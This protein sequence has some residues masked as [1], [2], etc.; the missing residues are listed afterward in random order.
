MAKT[1]TKLK[2]KIYGGNRP[3]VKKPSTKGKKNTKKG[4]RSIMGSLAMLRRTTKKPNLKKKPN[5]K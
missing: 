3:T 2:S 5:R 1:K 4:K